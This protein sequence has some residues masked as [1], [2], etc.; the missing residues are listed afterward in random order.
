MR[1]QWLSSNKYI[2]IFLNQPQAA[3]Y[4]M[5][6]C[7]KCCEINTVSLTYGSLQVLLW[8]NDTPIEKWMA[9]IDA[10]K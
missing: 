10:V 7:Y 2:Q 1:L 4:N 5:D 9:A 8:N 3:C 6:G